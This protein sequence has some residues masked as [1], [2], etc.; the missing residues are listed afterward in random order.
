LAEW[1]VQPWAV[2]LRDEQR[3]EVGLVFVRVHDVDAAL[4][5]DRAQLRHD[6]RIERMGFGDLD[7]GDA[8]R[9]RPLVD[10]EDTVALIADVTHGHIEAGR[11]GQRRA[12]QDRLLRPAARAEDAA[13][14]EDADAAVA[15]DGGGAAH[16]A[17]ASRRRP[18]PTPTNT[19]ADRPRS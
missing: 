17:D 19:A 15:R 9:P 13:Q 8:E 4:A 11:V 7:V 10:G 6:R 3:E 1:P 18:W 12:E 2:E 5:H 14:F 16:R